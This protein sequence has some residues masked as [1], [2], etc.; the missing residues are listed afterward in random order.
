MSA[1]LSDLVQKVIGW[2]NS[3]EQVEAYA[4]HSRDTEVDVHKGVIETLSTA[5]TDGVGIRVVL[6][7]P[8]GNRQ[9]FAYTGSL[10]DESLR[11]CLIA[12]RD[13]ASFG[14]PDPHLGLAEPDGIEPS[15]LDLYRES[16]ASFPTSE[17]IEL[18]MELERLVRAGDSRI[19]SLRSSGY[20]DGLLEVAIASTTGVT[21]AYRRTGVSISA[22]ANAGTDED[23]QTGFGYSVG[24]SVDELDVQKA[25]NMAVDRSTRLLGSVKPTSRRTAVVFDPFVTSSLLSILGGTLNAEAVIKGRSLFA[26]RVGQEVA[27]S[28]FSLIDQPTNPLAYGATPIDAEGLATREL[29]L[30]SKGVLQGF[31]H[32]TV[33]A[34]RMGNGARST[35]SATR[36]GFKGTPGVGCRALSV[37][38][39]DKSQKEIF[40]QI[41][42]GVLIQ[43]VSGLHSG[44]NPVSGD[45]SVG[46]EGLLIENGELGAPIRE[47]TIAS[48]LQRMLMEILAVGNDLEWLPGG[49]AGVSLAIDGMSL[50]GA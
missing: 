21:R 34:R 45:F 2:S 19:R 48:T 44:V 16:L 24:R 3:G 32:N 7:G 25:A 4:A 11:T 6:S 1:D 12:A 18:A 42:N 9:G 8:D 31:V 29:P 33:S 27:I 41:G 49:S 13:N 28:S 47:F 30:I 39:G 43:S 10:D 38:P 50:S 20:G 35:G 46:A 36:G 15:V 17:K 37:A 23:T 22:Q 26:D 5:E 40:K 14:T